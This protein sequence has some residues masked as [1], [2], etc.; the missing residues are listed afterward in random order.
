[1]QGQCP[2]LHPK[3]ILADYFTLG[4][5]KP[6]REHSSD[7]RL[8]SLPCAMVVCSHMVILLTTLEASSKIYIAKCAFLIQHKA[9]SEDDSPSEINHNL[10]FFLPYC[11]SNY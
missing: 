5:A 7:A 11:K 9:S 3:L 2:L 1:V 4:A 10:S 6:L 8:V